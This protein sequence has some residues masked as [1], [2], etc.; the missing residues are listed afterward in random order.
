MKPKPKLKSIPAINRRLLK[1]AKDICR[2]KA[3]NTCVV[4]GIKKGDLYKGKPQNLN[5]H[6]IM[7]CKNKNSPLKFD[8]RNIISLCV[9]CHKGGRRSAHKHGLWFAKWLIEHNPT[10]AQWIID[11]TDDQVDLKDRNILEYIEKCL[12]ENKP[13]DFNPEQLINNS[14][15]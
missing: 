7:S 13:L 3:N 14:N 9:F 2:Q 4:C 12:K 10:D 5:S 1:L 11:H 8:Q 15:E 6:H